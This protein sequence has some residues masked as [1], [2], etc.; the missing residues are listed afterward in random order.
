[1]LLEEAQ[2][3]RAIS[4]LMIQFVVCRSLDDFGFPGRV[5]GLLS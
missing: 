5:P 1:L 3:Q 2:K 4:P